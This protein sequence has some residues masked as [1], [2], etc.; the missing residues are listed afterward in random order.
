ML[1]IKPSVGGT[2]NEIPTGRSLM[3]GYLFIKETLIKLSSKPDW[4]LCN[5]FGPCSIY[6]LHSQVPNRK[7]QRVERTKTKYINGLG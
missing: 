5:L 6:S 4:C 1:G 2:P 3:F 7:M